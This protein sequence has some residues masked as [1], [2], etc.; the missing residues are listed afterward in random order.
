MMV[1]GNIPGL[2]QTASLAI[3]DAV[4]A[5]D[6]ARAGWLDLWISLVSIVAMLARAADRSR[7]EGVAGEHGDAGSSTSAWSAGST[8][9]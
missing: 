8:P 7:F 4:Q 1:A 5:G 9:V 2:T 3:Y 6:P